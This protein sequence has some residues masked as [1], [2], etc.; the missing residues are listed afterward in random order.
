MNSL[1]RFVRSTDVVKAPRAD[2]PPTP[3]PTA[4]PAPTWSLGKYLQ[5]LA[6]WW[7]GSWIVIV[8]LCLIVAAHKVPLTVDMLGASIIATLV[9]A[10]ASADRNARAVGRR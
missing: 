1:V 7:L 5:R 10:S 6:T 9:T 2:P 8:V 3:T 4:V